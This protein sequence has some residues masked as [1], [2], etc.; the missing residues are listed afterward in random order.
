MRALRPLFFKYFSTKMAGYWSFSELLLFVRCGFTW[1]THDAP[2]IIVEVTW[3]YVGDC[4]GTPILPMLMWLPQQWWEWEWRRLVTIQM[5]KDKVGKQ[6]ER[7][8]F[9]LN[10]LTSNG[11]VLELL[12]ATLFSA[13]DLPQI[14]HLSRGTIR[15]R[16]KVRSRVK[17][18]LT[19]ATLW[20][21]G[22]GPVSAVGSVSPWRVCDQTQIL[23]YHQTW[24]ITFHWGL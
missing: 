22:Q 14:R 16:L 18:S 10:Y 2:R 11:W 5:I 15:I 3:A 6:C 12:I 23:T 8:I 19:P 20:S 4:F 13:L 24:H 21:P 9:F 17:V 7:S 1:Q